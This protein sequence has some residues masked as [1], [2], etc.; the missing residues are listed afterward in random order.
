MIS[1]RRNL[2]RKLHC[3]RLRT[4]RRIRRERERRD[5]RDAKRRAFFVVK[6]REGDAI[7][8]RFVEIPSWFKRLLKNLSFSLFLPSVLFSFFL[9]S[10]QHPAYH[11]ACTSA[12]LFSSR[13]NCKLAFF[14]A[15]NLT[16][17][18]HTHKSRNLCILQIINPFFL[19]VIRI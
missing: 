10:F 11:R 17:M 4:R 12:F 19:F 9:Y 5:G 14:F 16:V 15:N 3:E 13:L 6:Q 1:A 7:R 8:T 2:V 18:I